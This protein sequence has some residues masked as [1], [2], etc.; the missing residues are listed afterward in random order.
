MAK[1]VV[2]AFRDAGFGDLTVLARN[3]TA[4]PALADKYGYRWV[5]ADPPPADAI[6]VNVTPLGMNG[7]DADALAFAGRSRPRARSSTSSPSR[8]RRP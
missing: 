2:A 3:A 8:P 7:A 1:A 4:G 5:Q 6:I